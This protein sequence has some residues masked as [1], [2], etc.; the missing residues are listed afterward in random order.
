MRCGSTPYSECVCCRT[1]SR[2]VRLWRGGADV[3][4]LH[5][6]CVQEKLQRMSPEEREKYKAR[7]AKVEQKRTARK[8]GK[9]LSVVR[10]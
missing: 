2:P 5:T 1:R 4:L 7:K 6:R 3:A 9:G 10:L 8:V